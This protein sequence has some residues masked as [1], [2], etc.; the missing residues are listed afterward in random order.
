M[1]LATATNPGGCQAERCPRL[2][3]VHPAVAEQVARFPDSPGIYVFTDAAGRAL[4]VG[5]AAN[6]RA[7]VRSYLKPGG[8]GRYLLRFLEQRAAAVEFVATRTEAEALLLENT[9]IK[10]RKPLCNIRL[11]DDKAFLL[12]RIDPA[13]PWPWFRLVRRRRDD[14]ARYFGPYASAKAVRRTLRLLHKVVPLRDCTDTVFRNRSRPCL[15]H[16]IGRCPAPCVGLI[17][18]D[19]YLRQIDRACAILAGRTQELRRELQQQMQ[20]AA[21]ALQFERA[22]VLKEQLAALG[23]VAEPQSVVGAGEADQ[24]AFGLHRVGSEVVAVVLAF[25]DGQLESS[26]RFELRS[27]LPD[28]LLLGELLQRY[29]E[30]DQYLPPRVLVPGPVADQDLL[31]AWLAGRRGSRVAILQPV[32]G[33]RRRELEMANENARLV[34]AMQADEAQRGAML[35][36]AV[37]DRL[38]LA[39]PPDRIHGLDVSTTQGK[40]TVASR[41][42]F[43]GGRPDKAGY[44]R[45]RIRGDAARDDFHALAEAVRRSLSLCLQSDGDDELPDLLLIDGGR[46]QLSAA[47]TAVDELALSDEVALAALAKSR[48]LGRGPARRTSDERAFLP[49][50]REPIPLLPGAAETRLLAGVRD[51]AHRFAVTYHRKVRGSLASELDAIR[52]VGPERRRKLLRHFGSL[53]AVRAATVEEIAAVPG[54]PRR[55]AEQIHEQLA[56]RE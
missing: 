50:A 16:Q 6:L 4:Y 11:K 51:E 56:G 34:D 29:Y 23:H 55:V 8:D 48:V 17:D 9:V 31:E 10:K 46:G 52:G 7:R 41:V 47:T 36:Q 1:T 44:R 5:K 37:A 18:R 13:E 20:Q 54:M 32:R 38:G 33:Q 53:S 39:T 12:L 14:G 21:E 19:T 3:T 43:V 25:R 15:K 2:S 26:R 35:V 27:E 40:G 45:F 22:Q 42:C 49:G 30:G 24:D 28:E